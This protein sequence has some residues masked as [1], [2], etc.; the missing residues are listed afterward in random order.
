MLKRLAL[1]LL[2]LA[3]PLEAL[4]EDC[5]FP[6]G[7]IT[8]SAAC[9]I[10]PGVFSGCTC[11]AGDADTWIIPEDSIVTIP[12]DA[13]VT[14][15]DVSLTNASGAIVVRKNGT[16]ILEAAAGLGIPGGGLTVEKG[17]KLISRGKAM[18]VRS[19]AGVETS[20]P[21]YDQATL[22]P[23]TVLYAG[24]VI[25]C[26]GAATKISDCV[27]G[28]T[29]AGSVQQIGLCYPDANG[30]LN[31]GYGKVS[32]GH[33]GETFNT[34]RTA[35]VAV[36]DVIQFW[37]PTGGLYPSRDVNTQYEIVSIDTDATD[38]C[39]IASVRQGTVDLSCNAAKVGC[40]LAM[41]D[42]LQVTLSS[43]YTRNTLRVNVGTTSVTA[44]NQRKGRFLD[45]PTDRDENGTAEVTRQFAV[46]S[47]VEDDAGGDYLTLAPPGL[48]HPVPNTSTCFISYGWAQGDPYSLY[49]PV[50]LG[51]G[52]AGTAN[53]SRLICGEGA[54]CDISFT[55]MNHLGTMQ[56]RN[57]TTVRDSWFREGGNGAGNLQLEVISSEQ[58]WSR[59]QMTSPN[60]AAAHMIGVNGPNAAPVF[61]DL[62]VR[63][64]GDDI[65][66]GNTCTPTGETT[67]TAGA[68]TTPRT[69]K[70][71]VRRARFEFMGCGGTTCSALDDDFTIAGE[72]M[73]MDVRDVLFRDAE[74]HDGSSL[75]TLSSTATPDGSYLTVQ[76][77]ANIAPDQR[78]LQS[79]TQSHVSLRN[80][81]DLDRTFGHSGSVGIDADSVVDSSFIGWQTI[82]T[83]IVSPANQHGA[84]TIQRTLFLSQVNGAGSVPFV[85]LSNP[86]DGTAAVLED[87]AFVNQR[88]GALQDIVNVGGSGG[89][90]GDVI[91][92][93]ITFAQRPGLQDSWPGNALVWGGD[94]TVFN[95]RRT[96]SG[97]LAAFW[98]SNTGGTQA[99]DITTADNDGLNGPFCF[100]NNDADLVAGDS[101]PASAKVIRDWRSP[102]VDVDRL[103]FSVRPD[104]AFAGNCGA[105][106]PGVSDSWPLRVLGINPYSTAPYALTWKT[107]A[108]GLR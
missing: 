49:R 71:T 69:Y 52:T 84:L 66:L 54:T 64:A 50:L 100:H 68:D 73:I 2:V 19:A 42:V 94:D 58:T 15:L 28:Q 87:V 63:H 99:L 41:R 70:A 12:T 76:N 86:V 34:E 13:V 79:A 90:L 37:D 18:S 43:A 36:G 81:L 20:S 10:S 77:A 95:T 33:P 83:P 31:A 80:F 92:R 5:T 8:W 26:P 4:A 56:S 25:H 65:I 35:A 98:W 103:N 107:R 78:L 30:T 27:G 48:P 91:L 14:D 44:D 62:T 39:L 102:F 46:I 21:A 74:G 105:V 16:L 96:A 57:G 89:D 108:Y 40:Q 97:I 17:G 3:L 82:D 9:T 51:D 23:R 93:R 59:F 45:C 106:N 1:A 104:S 38:N 24:N 101:L 55:V 22:G 32:A 75:M 7:S 53:D 6:T 11:G 60:V 85:D 47:D 29:P 88:M 72:R 61:E 67:C